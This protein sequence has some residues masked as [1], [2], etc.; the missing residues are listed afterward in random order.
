MFRVLLDA[1]APNILQVFEECE[2]GPIEPGGVM[3]KAV[4]IRHRHHF[5][6]AQKCLFSRE[7]R[8]IAGPRNGDY[9]VGDAGALS[10][11]HLLGEIQESVAGGFL[12]DPAAAPV[13][14][15][16]G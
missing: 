16:T 13:E 15:L 1:A 11:E 6:A 4:G 5:R 14:T 7:L 9:F 10:V 12:A 8:H 3:N 2:L